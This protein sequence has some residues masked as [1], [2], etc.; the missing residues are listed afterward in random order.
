MEKKTDLLALLDYIHPADCS[1][2]EWTEVGMALKQEGYSE[3]DWDLWSSRD[4]VRYHAGECARKWKTFAGNASPVTGGT[5]YQMALERL[6]GKK[7]KE[8]I[9]YSFCLNEEIPVA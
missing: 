4:P 2:K 8:K 7:V 5:I 9:I 3:H 6:T 1:Y